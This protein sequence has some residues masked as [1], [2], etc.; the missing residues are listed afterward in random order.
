MAHIDYVKGLVESMGD[1]EFT[2]QDIADLMI[3]YWKANRVYDNRF[4]RVTKAYGYLTTLAKW[5][6]VTKTRM[7]YAPT[8]RVKV[9]Y[10][11]RV[12]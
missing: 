7:D 12:E 1:R 10:W 6:I 2:T 9:A 5:G 3:D 11:R 4:S 8:S